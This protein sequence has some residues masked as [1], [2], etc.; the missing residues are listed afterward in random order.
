[1][2]MLV[3]GRLW[4][5][6]CWFHNTSTDTTCISSSLHAFM[7]F[8]HAVVYSF[9]LTE[10]ITVGVINYCTKMMRA[11]SHLGKRQSIGCQDFL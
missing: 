7:E 8:V 1:M 5:L 4:L 9:S 10:R 6:C 2:V 3:R 11:T